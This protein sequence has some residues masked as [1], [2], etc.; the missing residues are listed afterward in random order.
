[1]DEYAWYR[2]FEDSELRILS[3][4]EEISTLNLN[5]RTLELFTIIIPHFLFLE[6]AIRIL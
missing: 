3:A 4:K 2:F 6:N 5:I 1:M